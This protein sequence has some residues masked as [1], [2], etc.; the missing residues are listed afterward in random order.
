MAGYRDWS[1]P[2]LLEQPYFDGRFYNTLVEESP[3]SIKWEP[4]PGVF[5]LDNHAGGAVMQRPYRGEQ[6]PALGDCVKTTVSFLAD[7]EADYTA[8]RISRARC[9]PVVFVPGTWE[10][11]VFA[12]T[13][14][15]TYMLNRAP[16]AGI[17]PTPGPGGVVLDAT[18]L[19]RI[20][21]NGTLTPGAASVSGRQVVALATG[22]LA[23]WHMAAYLV[24]IVSNPHEWKAHNELIVS[25]EVE[26]VHG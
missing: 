18:T 2:F 25:F 7:D 11:E 16:A 21:L 9:A 19:L 12:A 26:E 5:V 4:S 20:Y 14:G 22:E 13:S 1:I 6:A 3:G 8:L 17:V 24:A 10:M 23:I 15:T